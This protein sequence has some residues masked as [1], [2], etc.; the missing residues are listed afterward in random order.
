MYLV[1]AYVYRTDGFI[2]EVLISVNS[3][4]CHGLTDF[5]STQL[6]L[7]PSFQFNHCCTYHSLIYCNLINLCLFSCKY[8]KTVDILIL[9]HWS[10]WYKRYLCASFII[11]TVQHFSNVTPNI[12]DHTVCCIAICFRCHC[13]YRAQ[14]FL[15]Q[16][17]PVH[18]WFLKNCFCP[19]ICMYLCVCLPPGY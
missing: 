13:M 1:L 14:H 12:H 17:W 4:R 8:F 2:C 15:N 11:A 16:A 18:A 9:L 5:N 7:L 19:D 10:A 6:H 3:V